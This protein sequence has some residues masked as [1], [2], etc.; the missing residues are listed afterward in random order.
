M[1][2]TAPAG[3]TASLSREQENILLEES[4]EKTIPAISDMIQMW[5]SNSQN[6]FLFPRPTDPL[7]N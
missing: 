1:R 3:L 6:E 2:T 5:A 7:L 4:R